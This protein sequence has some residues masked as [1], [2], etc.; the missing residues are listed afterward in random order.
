MCS[1]QRLSTV[2]SEMPSVITE[3]SN[4]AR[5]TFALLMFLLVPLV[6][7]AQDPITLDETCRVKVANRTTLA[8]PDG[9]FVIRNISIFQTRVTGALPQLNRV[10]A[11]CLRDGQ[12]IR[13][14]SEYFDLLPGQDTFVADVFPSEISP[15]PRRITLSVDNPT[16][17]NG[18]TRQLTVTAHFGD[19]ST[20]DVSSRAAGTTFLVTRPNYLTVSEDGLVTGVSVRPK[21]RW[22]TVTALHEGNL[23]TIRMRSFGPPDDFDSDGMPNDWEDRFGLNKF[24]DDGGADLD[25]DGLTNF[26]EY[27]VGTLPNRTDTDLDTLVD[28]L[29]NEPL[30]YDDT[31]PLVAFTSPVAGTSFLELEE[32][33]VTFEASDNEVLEEVELRLD[34]VLIFTATSS[35]F[36]HTFPIPRAV[37]GIELEALARDVVGNTSTATLPLNVTLDAPPEVTLVEPAEGALVAEGSV[38]SIAAEATDDIEVLDV[39]FTIDGV[40]RDPLATPPYA[41]SYPVDVGTTEITIEVAAR[42]RIQTTTTTRTVTVTTD[43]LTTVV[44]RTVDASGIPVAGAQLVTNLGGSGISDTNGDFSIPNI[45]S[46]QGSVQVTALAAVVGQDL[47]GLSTLTTPVSGGLTQV[48]DVVLRQR[49]ALFPGRRYSTGTTPFDAAFADFNG[50]GM[51]DIAV[52]NLNSGDLSVLLGGGN[53]NFAE[54]VQITTCDSPRE[55]VTADFNGDGAMDLAATCSASTSQHVA[56]HLGNGLGG[57]GAAQLVFSGPRPNGL[58]AAD[59][60]GDGAFDLAVTHRNGQSVGVLKGMGDGMFMTPD[61]L[62]VGGGPVRVEAADMDADGDQD[63]VVLNFDGPSISLLDNQGDGSF[64]PHVEVTTSEIRPNYLTLGDMNADGLV[65]VAVGHH[66]AGRITLWQGTGSTLLANGTLSLPIGRLEVPELVDMDADGHLDLLVADPSSNYLGYLLRG[67]GDGTFGV[68]EELTVGAYGAPLHGRDVDSDGDLD[69]VTLQNNSDNLS[70][71]FA[72][73]PGVLNVPVVLETL[74]TPVEVVT[75]DFNLDGRWDVAT[76]DRDADAVS[77]FLGNGDSTFQPRRVI[78]VDLSPQKA[79][80]VDYSGDGIPDLVVANQGSDTITPL[81]GFGDGNFQFSDQPTNDE[82]EDLALGDFNNDGTLDLAVLNN[83]FNVEQVGIHL[84]GEGG[85]ADYQLLGDVDDP[86]GIVAG[87]FNEDGTPDLAVSSFDAGELTVLLAIGNGDG[88]FQVG[89]T[90][91]TG[92]QS[93]DIAT[94]DLDQDGHLDLVTADSNSGNGAFS[95]LFGRGDGTFE[96]SLDLAVGGTTQGVVIGDLNLDGIPDIVGGNGADAL[97]V[98]SNGDRTFRPVQR[99]TRGAG[100]KSAFGDF[101]GDGKVD[102]AVT[103]GSSDTLW[104]LLQQ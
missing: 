35:P 40:A 43:P 73:S 85:F 86:L 2:Y 52:A 20:A 33:A 48:G 90:F 32:V 59:F 16:I 77:V 71:T 96:S 7:L 91:A 17:A 92:L 60:N 102:L 45:P 53:G 87:D 63:L 11:T 38:L 55:V 98:L 74:D 46:L 57:F 15:I 44:G 3:T 67:Q 26:E 34:G 13:G 83:A 81:R 68:H 29:D 30:R 50:D 23:A 25:G 82:P 58:V 22:I 75:A 89:V 78:E 65:D 10:R 9:T 62:S 31:P 69:L 64:A 100:T 42:D 93:Y 4:M 12:M 79:V 5:L 88:D 61:V 76:V 6:S 70:V 49:A 80:V 51:L 24:A 21:P 104:I 99:Y 56:L 72:T 54:G 18:E 37:E 39:T 97:V 19:G 101:N 103:G 66:I 36:S 28:G 47:S 94:G 14:Q 27:V 84:S 1:T 41:V 95:I 8:Q